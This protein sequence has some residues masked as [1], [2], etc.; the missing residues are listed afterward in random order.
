ME[1]MSRRT[2]EATV[3]RWTLTTTRSPVRS[4]AACTWAIEAEAIGMRSND[5]KTSARGRPSSSSI[6]RR[7]V[8]KRSGGTRSRRSWNSSTSSSGKIPS[9]EEMICPSLM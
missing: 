7:T 8:A 6:V 9:P 3:R 1:A 4:V 5:T 2:I